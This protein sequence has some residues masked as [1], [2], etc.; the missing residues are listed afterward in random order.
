MSS[1]DIMNRIKAIIND[2]SINYY[3]KSLIFSEEKLIETFNK[4][5][6]LDEYIV[7]LN[8]INSTISNIIDD[9]KIVI[10]LYHQ[11][12]QL[13][14]YRNDTS[15]N[16]LIIDYI[17]EI[18]FYIYQYYCIYLDII[19][20][21]EIQNPA[22]KQRTGGG[23]RSASDSDIDYDILNHILK[24]K[25]PD[26]LVNNHKTY[27]QSI[28]YRFN[29]DVFKIS[30]RENKTILYELTIYKSHILKIRNKKPTGI[31]IKQINE[32]D[33][34]KE[35]PIEL[36]LNREELTTIDDLNE[37]NI[38]FYLILI[39]YIRTFKN[40]INNKI[41]TIPEH[42]K[43]ITIPQY[44]GNC[45]FI[46]M[47]TSIAYS[48]LNRELIL[49]KT[50]SNNIFSELIYYIIDNITKY[51]K[52]YTYNDDGSIS[53]NDINCNMYTH[54][55]NGPITTLRNIIKY[56]NIKNQENFIE[57][58]KSLILQIL[59]IEDINNT[60]KLTITIKLNNL[61]Q[62]SIDDPIGYLLLYNILNILPNNQII[63]E[64]LNIDEITNDLI[65][66]CKK[67][68]ENQI[69]YFGIYFTNYYILKYLYELLGINNTL[70]CNL[71]VDNTTFEFKTFS[72]YKLPDER[73]TLSEP[74]I[75]ILDKKS[76]SYKINEKLY[77]SLNNISFKEDT[78]YNT[79]IY[80]GQEYILDYMLHT[81]DI[82]CS[83][84]SCGHCISCINYHGEQY[85]YDSKN[86]KNEIICNKDA[87]P[88]EKRYISCPLLNVKWKDNILKDSYYVVNRC[89]V[90]TINS[91]YMPPR[92]ILNTSYHN[93][94]Y[95]NNINFILVY[96]KKNVHDIHTSLSSSLLR[97]EYEGGSNKY[98]SLHKKIEFTYNN[99]NY[100]R[101][102]Y[103]NNKKIYVKINKNYILLSKIIK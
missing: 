73:Q 27:I 23:K 47:I 57:N 55:M 82:I 1:E 33:I 68:R 41:N 3:Y 81:H 35:K 80:N 101:I 72:D 70:F 21:N 36:L 26:I 29:I 7:F 32:D 43:F 25:Y 12:I 44:T 31:N 61:N 5:E 93:L 4:Y 75:I 11:L 71:K 24:I 9:L 74:E 48:D 42:N 28:I 58:I 65:T 14:S 97:S 89:G 53:N 96:V 84:N 22:K 64:N 37:F 10:E 52:E 90:K 76:S 69:N 103:V 60:I 17:Y 39:Y 38:K 79:V 20:Y 2:F 56:E 77:D 85:I 30:K 51:G 45:W 94:T 59:K 87:Q 66:K 67:L 13:E 91:S 8:E 86:I 92:Q 95:N 40:F 18:L 99:K 34:Y 63:Y 16:V 15:L 46:S 50:R 102:L 6:N 100:V 83:A 88:P 19:A 78:N 62:Y 49:S 98:I 54:L